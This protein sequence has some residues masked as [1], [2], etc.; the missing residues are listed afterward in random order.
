MKKRLDILLSER[1]LAESREKAKALIMSG[2]V[3]VNNEKQ[4]KAGAEFLVNF[5]IK[6]YDY[7]KYVSR[8]GYKLEKAISVFD[9]DLN[10]KDLLIACLKTM[11]LKFTQ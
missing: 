8:G 6:L 5:L 9:I 3:F 4:D 2:V 1:G 10:G 7:I 11:L